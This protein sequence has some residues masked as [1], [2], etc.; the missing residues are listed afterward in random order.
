MSAAA[1]SNSESPAVTRMRS[2]FEQLAFHA[3]PA[4]QT[5]FTQFTKTGFPTPRDEGW[6]YTNLRRLESREFLAGNQNA[7]L[8]AKPK[9][10]ANAYQAVFVDG[11]FRSELST[12]P[13]EKDLRVASITALQQSTSE[14]IDEFFTAAPYL[15]GAMQ[16]LNTALTQDGIFIEV[17][18][19]STLKL[20][21]FLSFIWSD[22]G[23]QLMAHPR[24]VIKAGSHSKLTV[25]QEYIGSGNH[26][27]FNNTVTILQLYEAAHLEHG[28]IQTE[29]TQSFNLHLIHAELSAHAK[30]INHHFNLGG[31]LARTDV[32]VL[33]KGADASVI[34]NGLQFANGNQHH[35][36]HLRI[37]HCVP[38]TKSSQDYRGIADQRGRIVFNGKVKVL[39]KASK[40]DAQQS[41]RNLLLSS[42]AE[43]DTKP[44]LEIYNDDVKCAHGATVGQLDSTALFYLRSRGLDEHQARALL[45]HAFA[46]HIIKQVSVPELQQQLTDLCNARFTTQLEAAT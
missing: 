5:A 6:K 29:N 1:Q 21:L 42:T 32:N 7:T 39:E 15:S 43:I 8:Q 28:L 38:H 46:H 11:F 23:H 4:R 27:H 26:S 9:K 25:I 44:E 18:A 45:T 37:E 22:S 3:I 24:I 41:S 12:L 31:A 35:D 17:P 33:L 40:T 30:L 19:N 2:V 34:L 36:T 16:F 14:K 10:P 20:P 13:D